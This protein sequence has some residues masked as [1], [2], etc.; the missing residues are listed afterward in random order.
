MLV[1]GYIPVFF[2]FWGGSWW[3]GYGYLNVYVSVGLRVWVMVL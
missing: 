3:L 2:V 1:V